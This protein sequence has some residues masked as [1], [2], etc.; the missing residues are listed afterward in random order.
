MAA[1]IG[2]DSDRV[3]TLLTELGHWA[4]RREKRLLER[5][6]KAA[7]FCRRMAV[8]LEGAWKLAELGDPSADLRGWMQRAEQLVEAQIAESERGRALWMPPAR[9]L[10]TGSLGLQ[11]LLDARTPSPT[12]TSQ[13]GIEET[14]HRDPVVAPRDAM[15]PLRAVATVPSMRAVVPAEAHR[16]VRPA[17]SGT[18]AV[19]ARPTAIRA[20][21]PELLA[22]SRATG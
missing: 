5:D 19:Q 3:F 11:A 10:E 15:I 8:A 9:Q 2:V 12:E 16:S 20:I 13:P 7:T 6:P 18:R 1:N 21:T 14:P 4:L 17:A 22:L